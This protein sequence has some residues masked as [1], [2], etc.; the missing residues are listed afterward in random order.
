MFNIG[1][2]VVYPM[3]GAG[4][5]VAIE[6]REILGK[7]REYYVLKMPINDMEVMVPVINAGD[8]GVRDILGK[9]EMDKVLSILSSEDEA[10]MPTNWNRRYRYNMERIKTGDIDEIAKV[11]RSL[12]KLDVEKTLSTG[13]RKMLLSARQIIISE[14]VL[15]YEKSTDEISDLVDDIIMKS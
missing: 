3:H 12:E 2:K 11:V 15:V 10:V 1:D 14:M 6:N 4:I 7:I 8:V 13:E 5:I 9:E